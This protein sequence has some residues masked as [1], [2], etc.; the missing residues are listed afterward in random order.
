MNTNILTNSR[1]LCLLKLT[2]CKN[3]NVPF[4]YVFI[5][6]FSCGDK[7]NSLGDRWKNPET[8]YEIDG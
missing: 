7:R 3:K 8:W 6:T 4:F 1:V 2:N 5:A